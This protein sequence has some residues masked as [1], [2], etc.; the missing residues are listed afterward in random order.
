VTRPRP[1]DVLLK[2]YRTQVLRWNRQISLVSRRDS[3]A[4]L[5]RLLLQCREGLALLLRDWAP[6]PG[7]VYYDLGSGGG[8]PGVVWHLLLAERG[9]AP[10]TCLVEP[11]EK[12]AWFLDRLRS[13]PA[14]PDFRVAAMRWGETGPGDTVAEAGDEILISLKAL[15]LTDPAVVGGLPAGPSPRRLVIARYYPPGEPMTPGLT[16]ELEISEP[17]T[18]IAGGGVGWLAE[19]ARVLTGG[20]FSL[21]VST[22]GTSSS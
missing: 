16:A 5:D 13:L 2:E 14:M 11:R 19:G 12:R 4:I 6:P 3:A 22:Y 15:K 1:A 9:V 8:L 17:G 7:L 21:V 10:R 20:D 18:E